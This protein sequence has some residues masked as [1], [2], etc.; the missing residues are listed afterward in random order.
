[1][2]GESKIKASIQVNTSRLERSRFAADACAC[3]VLAA[4][5]LI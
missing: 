4:E 1:L 3:A 5:V 2:A